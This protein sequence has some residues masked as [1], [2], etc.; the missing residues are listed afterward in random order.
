[1][2][3]FGKPADPMQQE[4][5]NQQTLQQQQMSNQM[6]M[7]APYMYEQHQQNQAVLVEQTNPNHVIE[8]VELSLRGYER[9][10]DGTLKKV[11]EPLMNELGIARIRT[12][13]K[14]IVNQNTILSHLEENQISKLIIQFSDDLI[15]DL[16]LNWKEY[17]MM[18]KIMLDYVHDIVV[19]PAY[20]AL[21]RALGQNEKNWLGKISV[22]NIS[23][24]PRIPSGKKE[25]FWNKFRL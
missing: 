23:N 5:Y 9:K 17:G 14:G 22:E 3:L 10:Y 4:Y 16:T 2:G 8:E 18:D 11:S 12:M 15:D 24:A 20:L 1:M 25:G 19:F 6:N 21:Q 7:N 13:M